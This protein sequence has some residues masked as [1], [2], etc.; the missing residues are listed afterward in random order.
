M[1]KPTK[2]ESLKRL[3]KTYPAGKYS[4]I[5]IPTFED[6]LASNVSILLGFLKA[7]GF[8]PIEGSWAPVFRRGKMPDPESDEVEYYAQCAI[9]DSWRAIEAKRAGDNEMLAYYCLNAG[10]RFG[11]AYMM[12]HQ[13]RIARVGPRKR[14][15]RTPS[16]HAA[17]VERARDVFHSF[18]YARP[19]LR[20]LWDRCRK[21]GEVAGFSTFKTVLAAA[22]FR[23]WKHVSAK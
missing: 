4:D 11:K 7:R 6:Q 14:Q 8:I 10:L 5:Q 18:K 16:R 3:L 13:Q 12:M 9:L 15:A 19:S 23:H 1:T 20:M 22:G 21:Q 17:I 2:T